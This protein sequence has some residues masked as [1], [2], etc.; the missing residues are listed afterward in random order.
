VLKFNNLSENTNLVIKDM[1]GYSLYSENIEKSGEI[2]SK[3][4]DLNMLPDGDYEIE[5]EGTE[6]F[7]SF[8]FSVVNN[9][10]AFSM[11]EKSETYK[12][13]FVES[14][15]KVMVSKINPDKNPL[16]VFIYNSQNE[17][18]YEETLEGKLES[19]RI[20]N[21]SKVQGNYTIAIQSDDK[22]YSK[23]VA[24]K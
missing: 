15:N 8:P 13:T 14:G 6:K 10:I 18:V 7:T 19:G 22:S 5:V 21:F 4:Y 12:P 17:L 9:K 11:L 24:I 23:T 16:Y 1:N 3:S 2:F 20:Y